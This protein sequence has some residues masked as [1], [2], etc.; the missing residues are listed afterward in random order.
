MRV[1]RTVWFNSTYSSSPILFKIFISLLM[2]ALLYFSYSSEREHNRMTHAFK[3]GKHIVIPN[4]SS[5]SID[6]SLTGQLIHFS[7]TSLQPAFELE[8][9]SFSISFPR[10]VKYQR[11]TEYCQWREY[12]TDK[13]YE[14]SDGNKH[15]ERTYYYM[16]EWVSYL[17]PSLL[18]DQ[19]AAHHNPLR[20]PYPALSRSVPSAKVDAFELNKNLIDRMHMSSKVLFTREDPP[21]LVGPAF[22]QH[23]T[24]SNFRYIGDGYFYSSYAP[25]GA[26]TLFKVLGQTLEG[27]LLDY[28]L[29]DLFSQ[30]SAGDIRIHF[31]VVSPREFS[32][33]AKQVDSNGNLDVYTANNGYNIGI[34][35]K[36]F[37]DAH[38]MFD[39][40]LSSYRWGRVLY[41]RIGLILLSFIVVMIVLPQNEDAQVKVVGTLLFSAL[42]MSVI[43]LIVW[44]LSPATLVLLG[45][46]TVFIAV[47][48][49]GL[50]VTKEKVV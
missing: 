10:A 41:S 19:P 12:H 13:E 36:G 50:R 4:V 21:V 34:I 18:F 1:G 2:I 6:E 15:T 23:D 43:W 26:E 24:N 30:C 35:H 48:L 16:K 9:S 47:V 39:D 38:K 8:D 5:N 45:A 3:Q 46:S 42:F 25:S 27:T 32:V 11:H 33:I 29:G 37:K 14:D 44:G 49:P 7:S 40:E 31:T 22:S 17:V 28:Q 20:D